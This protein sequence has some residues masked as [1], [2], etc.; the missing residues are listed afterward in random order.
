VIIP[1][2]QAPRTLRCA[3]RALIQE[4]GAPRQRRDVLVMRAQEQFLDVN[5]T[6]YNEL[7]SCLESLST[8][9]DVHSAIRAN[10]VRF[11]EGQLTRLQSYSSYAEG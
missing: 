5:L 6:Y 10:F 9:N 7:K 3:L 4:L 2:P 8:D 1:G 11:C